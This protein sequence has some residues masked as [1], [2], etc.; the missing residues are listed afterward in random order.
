[1]SPIAK[2]IA[3]GILS[4]G[5]L[6]L[7]QIFVSLV[8]IRLVVEFLPDSLGGVWF[9]F[10]TFGLYISFFDLG[11]S[12]T[13]SREISFIRGTANVSEPEKQTQIAD[14]IQTNLRM[15]QIIALIVF[16]VGLFAG[17]GYF[18]AIGHE[19]VWWAW[20]VFMLGASFN[21]WGNANFSALYGLGNVA[22]E[23]VIR[24]VTQIIGLILSIVLLYL[25]FDL[26]G[27]AFAWTLQNSLA[28]VIGRIVLYRRYPFL[29]E[30]QGRYSKELL[31]KIV[32]P[33]LKWAITS[34]GALLILNTGN[35]II[36]INLGTEK[37]PSYEAVVKIVTTLSTLSIMII[38][39]S[40]PFVSNAF[41]AG[42][43]E[44]VKQLFTRNVKLGMALMISLVSFIAVFGRG[45]VGIWLGEENFA[46]E[47]VLW[48]LLLMLTLEVHHV[49]HATVIM[50]CGKVIFHW[51]AIFAGIFNVILATVLVKHYDLWGVALAIFLAQILTNNWYAP[52]KTLRFFKMS[53]RKYILSTGLPLTIYSIIGLCVAV[54]LQLVTQGLPSILSIVISFLC[55][56]A[57]SVALTYIL[58]LNEKDK[59]AIKAV[60]TKWRLVYGTNR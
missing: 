17:E 13:I 25:G 47:L 16:V 4:G 52:Y 36:S 32:M 40:T 21:L 2:K 27:L 51:V 24:S 19:G 31:K 14:L 45:I 35:V 28:R 7:I 3:F 12:P 60:F 29:R 55:C 34:L 41:A 6:T 15:F 54:G 50:A 30:V 8:Q 44:D 20:F 56:I 43:I 10:L 11:I 18:H 46:G 59:D 42:K 26:L 1:M 33:S 23:R 22:E 49:I 48:T 9:L 39:T 57:V 37:I 53:I 58:L 38:N 5:G